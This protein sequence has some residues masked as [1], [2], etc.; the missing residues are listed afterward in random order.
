VEEWLKFGLNGRDTATVEKSRSLANKH[1]IP[2]LGARKLRE[3]SADDVDQWF[4]REAKKVTTRTLQELRS[5]LKRS[6]ARAQ[7]RDKVKRNVVLLCE[8][9][10]G[11]PGRPSKS[12]TL[13]QAAA[14]LNAAD[15]AATGIRAYIVLSLLTG[16]RTEELRELTWSHLVAYDQERQAWIPLAEAGWAHEE[17]AIYVWRSVRKSG[18][19]KTNKSRRTLKLPQRCV[20]A[21]DAL[22]VHQA[23]ARKAAGN[24]WQNNDLVFAT[25]TGTPLDAHNVRRDF[26]KVVTKAG[27]V[28]AEW[29]PQ[30]M[31]HSFVS[32][33][34]ANGVPLEDISRLVGHAGTTV[35][36][37][38]YRLQIRPVMQE[39][40]TAMDR[41]F[42]NRNA[43]A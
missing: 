19:T 12:L 13:V 28:G 18:D 1:I 5:I 42:P 40:A 29:T 10:T 22:W 14:V 9:P 17:F 38:V 2:E 37:A 25:R 35:T 41:I 24:A 3:L 20:W 11:R 26:R 23:V 16:A 27:L 30:E 33:L 7:A 8:L 6:V 31:R 36:E 15:N 34:S 21:L 43:E 32:V 39:G 4:E